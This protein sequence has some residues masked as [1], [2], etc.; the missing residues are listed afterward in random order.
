LA[1]DATRAP[2][3][4]SQPSTLMPTIVT[5]SPVFASCETS[6]GVFGSNSGNQLTIGYGYELETDPIT[7]STLTNQVIPALEIAFNNFLLPDLFPGICAQVAA[8]R[9]RLAVQ[10]IS[11]VQADLPQFGIPCQTP[12]AESE[13]DCFY[14][15]GRLMIFTDEIGTRQQYIDT[16]RNGLELGMTSG[17]FNDAQENVVKVTYVEADSNGMPVDDRP[18]VSPGRGTSAPDPDRVIDEA[19]DDDR[20]LLLPL[21][22]VAGAVLIVVTGVVTYRNT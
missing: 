4:T 7:L 21:L 1:P 11:T 14:M 9:R 10:G 13:N 12:K 6:G 15:R 20:D 2:D 19:A 8:G 16:V 22:L 17:A 5:E 3:A 18:T